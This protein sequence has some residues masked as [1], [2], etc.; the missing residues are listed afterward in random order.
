MHVLKPRW[1]GSGFRVLYL[2]PGAI[3]VFSI[4]AALAQPAMS[5][6]SS[7]V[8]PKVSTTQLVS[9]IENQK[10]VPLSGTV[11][12]SSS[13][14]IPSIAP[15]PGGG[16]S[17]GFNAGSTTV[18]YHVWT[19]GS[20]SLRIQ[21]RNSGGERDLYVTRGSVWLWD[22]SKLTA[23]R[24][25]AGLQGSHPDLS[26][27]PR[28]ASDIVGRLAPFASLQVGSNTVVAG[29]PVYTLSMVPTASSSL[30]GLVSVSVDAVTHIP[31]RVQV[32]PK[33]SNSPAVSIGFDTL[34]TSSPPPSVFSFVPPVG[35]KVQQAGSGHA[36]AGQGSSALGSQG[37]P[38][39]VIGSGFDSVF[40]FKGSSKMIGSLASVEKALP[41]ISTPLGMGR[42][43]ST[44]IFEAI[45]LPNGT[46]VAGPVDAARLLQVL[47]EL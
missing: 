20:G 15:F 45:M 30:V 9:W 47:G 13:F 16:S 31:I 38:T 26:M 14:P 22:S 18:S 3:A 6:V 5:T 19:N 7:P 40:V 10:P 37:S 17:A 36:H 1:S 24:E 25:D 8:L 39:K 33:S 11:T 23:V 34:S 44:P 28:S 12:F 41:A 35:A 46:V 21:Q 32:Y 29:R 27:P 42:V 43:Y 2:F 4:A